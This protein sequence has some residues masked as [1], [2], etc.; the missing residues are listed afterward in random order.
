MRCTIY[1]NGV[2]QDVEVQETEPNPDGPTT[3]RPVVAG[4]TF[5]STFDDSNFLVWIATPVT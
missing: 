5:K 4:F 3:Y 1:Y 2:P